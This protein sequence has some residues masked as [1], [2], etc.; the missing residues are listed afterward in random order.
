MKH[1][2]Q[3]GKR[4]CCKCG[5]IKEL[6]EFPLDKSKPK[7]RRYECNECYVPYF[8]PLLQGAFYFGKRDAAKRSLGW[9]ILF[10]QFLKLRSENCYYCDD[11]IRSTGSGLDRIDNSKGY[12]LDNVVP[13]C[14]PCNIVRAKCEFTSD[15]MLKYIGP[16]IREIKKIRHYTVGW[17]KN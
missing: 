1:L 13:C 5:A 4:R 11:A 6:N 16:A 15:E 17:C 8:R 7:G 9:E 14:G 3:E 10:D 2:R 12:T